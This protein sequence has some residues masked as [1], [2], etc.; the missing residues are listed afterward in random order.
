MK[1][2]ST[3]TV[4]LS[5]LF[6][7]ALAAEAQMPMPKP[8]P[9][10][11]KLDYF[12]GTWAMDAELKPGP[13]GPGGK[14]TETEKNDWMDGGF[15]MVIHEEFKSLT[16]GNG[17]GVAYM[18]YDENKKAYTYDA[19]NSWGEAEH[20]TGAVAGDTWTWNSEEKMGAQT[21]KARFV[22]KVVSATSYNFNFDMS[23]DG[24]T[25]NTVMD[26]TATKQ[27]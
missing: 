16:M 18:G 3:I 5:V 4:F 20:S 6:A 27:K 1:R 14:V 12:I 11:K 21:V 9:E 24:T 19:F 7:M 13:M 2:L 23:Q 8:A 25:W 15:F 17:S 22:V 26:G 10:L